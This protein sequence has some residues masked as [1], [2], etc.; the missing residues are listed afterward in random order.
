MF[1]KSSSYHWQVIGWGSDLENITRAQANE[2]F[3]TYYAPNNLTMILVG[4]LEPDKLIKTVREYFERIPR[5]TVEPPDVTTL[6]EKQYAEKR[7]IAT[8]ETSPQAEIW[9][10]TPAW[11]HDDSYALEVLAKILSGKTGRLYKKLVE[12]MDIAKGSG[13]GGGMFGGD[14]LEVGA[15][16]ESRKYAGAF[17]AYATGKSG[18]RAEDL[19]AAMH[20]VLEELK[21]NPVTEEELQK[22]KNQL[23]VDNIRFMDIMS[24][25]GILIYLGSNASYGD[26]TEANNNP[27]RCDVVTAADIQRVATTYF[28]QE[29]RNVLI[30][31][32]KGDGGSGGGD[33]RFAQA[34]G[35]IKGM[36]DAAQLEQMLG[37]FSARMDSVEDPEERAQMEELVKIAGER[38]KELKAAEKN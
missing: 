17:R 36:T 8:A 3:D 35:M 31:N 23:R 9:Y 7:V 2:Y 4:D 33:G 27:E 37:M 20:T 13:G 19:E 1:W 14:G 10:H 15:T 34:V 26:W 28:P 22:V 16:Q 6:E 12:E 21:T 38:L 24:G 29:Q 32:T 5:G 11:K 18:V 30:I 25:I